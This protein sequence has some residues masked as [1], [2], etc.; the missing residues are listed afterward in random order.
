MIISDYLTN[1][2]NKLENIKAGR[3]FKFKYVGYKDCDPYINT[4]EHY[5]C[6]FYF[7]K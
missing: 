3:N 5:T 6:V 7:F 2:F 1:Y 4:C